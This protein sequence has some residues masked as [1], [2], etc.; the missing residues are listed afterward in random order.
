MNCEI[1]HYVILSNYFAYP[2]FKDNISEWFFLEHHQSV[3]LFRE[4]PRPTPLKTE[5]SFDLP[6]FSAKEED[7][8]TVR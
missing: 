3:S 8:K 7:Q 5:K 6:L 4:M 1:P 2:T